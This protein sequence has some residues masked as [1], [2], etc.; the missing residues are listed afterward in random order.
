[1]L[2]QG[3]HGAIVRPDWSH[4]LNILFKGCSSSLWRVIVPQSSSGARLSRGRIVGICNLHK[5]HLCLE[6][7][8]DDQ[9]IYKPA[10]ITARRMDTG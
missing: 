1:M 8:K 5:R 2:Q 3:S 6:S 9:S 10:E 4:L 7:D